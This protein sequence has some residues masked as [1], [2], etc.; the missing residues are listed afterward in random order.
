MVGFV[1]QTL[2]VVEV[3]L[4]GGIHHRIV[5]TNALQLVAPMQVNTIHVKEETKLKIHEIH[6]NRHDERENQQK[7]RPEELVDP[8]VGDD[9]KRRRVEESVVVFVVTPETE[10][11]VT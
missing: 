3:M 8:F 1:H 4:E 11:D 7:C 9:G 10:I 5:G 2:G 6:V